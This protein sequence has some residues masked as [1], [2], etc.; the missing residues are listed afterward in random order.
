MINKKLSITLFT[1]SFA[2]FSGAIVATSNVHSHANS[3]INTT[4]SGDKSD[5][6]VLARNHNKPHYYFDD[7]FKDG[8]A[9]HRGLDTQFPTLGNNDKGRYLDGYK[10]GQ[11]VKSAVNIFNYQDYKSAFKQKNVVENSHPY[12]LALQGYED[13]LNSYT[14]KPSYVDFPS[15][16]DALTY[17]YAFKAGKAKHQLIAKSA[18]KAFKRGYK[19]GYKTPLKRAIKYPKHLTKKARANFRTGYRIGADVHMGEDY[20]RHNIKLIKKHA[21]KVNVYLAYNGYQ[22]GKRDV[23]KHPNKHV[24]LKGKDFRYKRG[25]YQAVEDFALKTTKKVINHAKSDVRHH[26]VMSITYAEKHYSIG[27]RQMYYVNYVMFS[28]KHAPKYVTVK[29]NIRS[30]KSVHFTKKNVTKH[31][32]KHDH[33][34]V[35]GVSFDN[36]GHARYKVGKLGYITMSPKFVK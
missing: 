25:Y 16:A 33:V 32:K 19:A 21:N 29:R 12:H 26:K 31:F 8:Y 13:G 30:H 14:G 23:T 11:F 34:K 5:L 6:A 3:N 10:L 27:Y 9:T 2:L 22:D 35:T 28:K 24:S 18:N 17:Q 4:I 36:H 20:A 15:T 1:A 7:G